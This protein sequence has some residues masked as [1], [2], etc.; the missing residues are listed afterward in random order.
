MGGAAPARARMPVEGNV[1]EP[2]LPTPNNLLEIGRSFRK[3]K[4]LLSAIELGLFTTLA[5]GPLDAEALVARL[6][7]QGRG[8]PDFFDA[9]VALGLL[10]RDSR[11]GTPTRRIARFISIGKSEA[12]SAGFSNI[13]T[14]ACMRI[15]AS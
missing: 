12:I 6:R 3:S 2:Q 8:A 11:V 5:D 1:L 9:R 14:L 10:D 4:A 15:G 7:L 13:S